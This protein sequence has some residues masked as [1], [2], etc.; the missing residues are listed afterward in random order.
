MSSVRPS[1]G[2]PIETAWN[3]WLR[4]R[5]CWRLAVQT[6]KVLMLSSIGDERELR[7]HGIP[8]V[9]LLSG[10][11]RNLQDHITF[12]CIGECRQPIAARSGFEATLDWKTDP[13]LVNP[14]LQFCQMELPI[15]G[16]QTTHCG[17]PAHGRKV[18]TGLVT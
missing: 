5:S 12:G 9:Q 14:D 10:V 3:S 2:R 7:P 6:P 16:A 17:I 8:V 18:F 13:V 15:P 1:H 11:G 4:R